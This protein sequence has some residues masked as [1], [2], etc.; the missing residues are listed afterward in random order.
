MV[1]LLGNNLL[2]SGGRLLG[3]L[4]LN[5]LGEELLVLLGVF[6]SGSAAGGLVLLDGPLAAETLLSNEALNL[7]GL[8]E[9]LVGTLDFTADNI[10]ADIILL[11]VKSEDLNDVVAA[12]HAE[13]VGALNVGDTLEVLVALLDNF[14]EESTDI[15]AN[16]AASAGLAGTLSNTGWFVTSATF[17]VEDAGSTV[18]EDTLLHLETLLI[19]TSANSED[20]ALELFTHDFAIDF[21]THSSVVEGTDAFFIVNFKLFLAT[22][23]RVCNVELHLL[24]LFG[25]FIGKI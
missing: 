17:L 1:S 12:L 20:V 10:L 24:K 8:E 11:F 5:V 18:D 21:L 2:L 4:L 13:S 22:S 6:L 16:D 9:S 3:L 7:G 25:L 23:G 15:W 14:K 19:V